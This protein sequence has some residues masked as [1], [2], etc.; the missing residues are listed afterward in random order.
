MQ[1]RDKA[2]ALGKCHL[3][4]TGKDSSEGTSAAKWRTKTSSTVKDHQTQAATQS[5]LMLKKTSVSIWAQI[6]TPAIS[7]RLGQS[8][9][10]AFLRPFFL[11]GNK[12]SIHLSLN[13]FPKGFQDS[14]EVC[15]VRKNPSICHFSMTKLPCCLLG[16][17]PAANT[18][19]SQSSE[20]LKKA[21]SQNK[22]SHGGSYKPHVFDYLLQQ[23]TIITNQQE[24]AFK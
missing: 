3:S 17:N 20:P 16:T 13:N 21:S 5:L 14:P 6:S 8:F 23:N 15:W 4:W 1:A 2:L 9:F 22:K 12:V 11:L 24:F 19:L 10:T 7:H 18:A